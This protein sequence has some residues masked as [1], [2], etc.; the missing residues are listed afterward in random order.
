LSRQACVGPVPVSQ[1]LQ[2]RPAFSDRAAFR[3]RD[4]YH[5]SD[6]SS[7]YSPKASVV[8]SDVNQFQFFR[9]GVVGA[10]QPRADW[11]APRD[12]GSVLHHSAGANCSRLWCGHVYSATPFLSITTNVTSLLRGRHSAMVTRSPV[13]LPCRVDC[14]R[15]F[16][17]SA[18]R[19]C[20]ILDN[21]ASRHAQ[22][23]P[24]LGILM[25]R[26]FF[27]DSSSERYTSV[28]WAE[29]IIAPS[30]GRFD[31]ESDVAYYHFANPFFTLSSGLCFRSG[32]S[33]GT[34]S[35][36]GRVATN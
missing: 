20:C 28:E 5:V 9:A 25:W 3:D 30:F 15:G 14:G 26:R 4:H 13:L 23:R 1:R 27:K 31:V 36:V 32:P 21:S 29:R 18:F 34:A 2:E 7:G 17:F 19:I 12:S 8:S 33:T 16:C 35:P 24:F 22:L 6:A 10:G 11:K